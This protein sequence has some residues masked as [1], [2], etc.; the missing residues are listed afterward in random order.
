MILYYSGTGNSEYVAKMIGDQLDDTCLNLFERLRLHDIHPI[1][2]KKPFVFVC[3]TYGWQ[4]PHLLRD[5]LK[6]VKLEGTKD[7]YF[8]LTCGADIGDAQTHLSK[9]CQD[10]KMNFKGCID[11]VM[12]EN[13][14]AMFDAPNQKEAL[15]IIKKSQSS[16]DR[17]IMIIKNKENIYNDQIT[18]I[19]QLKSGIVNKI[20]YAFFI[21]DK[22]FKV[23]DACIGCGKCAK[24]CVMDN[25]VMVDNKPTWNKNC[26]HCMACICGCPSQAI[27]YGKASLNKPRYQ[28][29]KYKKK[30]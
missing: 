12:P 8:V 18:L 7:I 16:I 6:E 1:D 11:I 26:T 17:A 30:K 25:I 13:Y 24:E 19:D 28:C 10:I 4:I 15:E 21:H 29:P 27:E 2:S 5:W 22:K 14:I 23:S 3:P 9:L 20:F